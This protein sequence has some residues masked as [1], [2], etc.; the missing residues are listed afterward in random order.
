MSAVE[1]RYLHENHSH[2]G[3]QAT[4]K[5]CF[6]LFVSICMPSLR[7]SV[8]KDAMQARMSP[9]QRLTFLLMQHALNESTQLTASWALVSLH[10]RWASSL[11]GA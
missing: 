1:G 11:K 10:G 3:E 4:G 2:T 5:D 8:E 6:W 7:D 9:L